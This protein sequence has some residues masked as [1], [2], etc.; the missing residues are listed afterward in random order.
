MA[1]D[2]AEEIRNKTGKVAE[3]FVLRN[4]EDEYGVVLDLYDNGKHL[5]LSKI[6]VPKRLRGEGIGTELMNKIIDFADQTKKDIRLT[7][8][9]SFGATSVGRLKDFYKRFG[10]VKNDDYAY[11]DTMVRDRKSVV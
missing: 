8:S 6:E 2:K 11:R 5:E 1:L 9:K 4:L 3:A 10:F 7:P